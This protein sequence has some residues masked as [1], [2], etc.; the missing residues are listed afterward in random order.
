MRSRRATQLRNLAKLGKLPVEGRSQISQATQFAK[1]SWASGDPGRRLETLVWRPW[2]TAE[3]QMLYRQ[4]PRIAETPF[5]IL[6]RIMGLRQ[7]LLRGLSKVNTE[8]LWMA[9]AFNLAKL[10]RILGTMRAERAPAT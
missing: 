7:F 9:T 3:G 8:F 1:S 6:K 2:A 10:V 4:R 5:A